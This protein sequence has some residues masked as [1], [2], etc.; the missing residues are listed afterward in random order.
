MVTTNRS[1][2]PRRE[3]EPSHLHRR[4]MTPSGRQVR[5]WWSVVHPKYPAKPPK[6]LHIRPPPSFFLRGW[7]W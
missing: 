2:P 6:T 3:F 1:Q 5:R 4:W 7:T